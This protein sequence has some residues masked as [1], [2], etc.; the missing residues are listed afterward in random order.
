MFVILRNL[1]VRTLN[2]R[3]NL[4]RY[5]VFIYFNVC[6]QNG[7]NAVWEP[8]ICNF[9]RGGGGERMP[10]EP[11]RRRFALAE[12]SISPLCTAYHYTDQ[13]IEHLKW[14]DSSVNTRR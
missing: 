3:I 6:S 9:L 1:T 4:A 5:L 13:D 14:L 8:L 12:F 10:S 2:I 11:K 7:G